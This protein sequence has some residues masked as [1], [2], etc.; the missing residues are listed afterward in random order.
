MI[1]V[2]VI[3]GS[4]IASSHG[5][6]IRSH[7]A[8]AR[9]VAVAEIDSAR[10]TQFTERWGGRGY[11]GAADLL[12]DPNV[13]AV[14]ICLPH[15]LHARTAIDAARAGK[16]V[17]VEKPMAVT[18]DECDQMIAAAREAGVKLMVAHTRRFYP[19]VL[20]VKESIEAGIIGEPIAADAR[21]VKNWGFKSR[22]PWYNDRARGGG[23]WLTNG[24]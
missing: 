6:A 24:V 7:A 8:L 13:D 3:G 19:G 5:Q 4:G 2:G 14:V 10:R 23:M 18:V 9:A 15:W 17:L 11:E 20:A 22:A 21:F 16:H 1:R 12:A